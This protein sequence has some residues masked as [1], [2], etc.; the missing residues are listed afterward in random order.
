MAVRPGSASRCSASETSGYSLQSVVFGDSQIGWIAK[1]TGGVLRSEDGGR[2]WSS[3]LD[4]PTDYVSLGARLFWM[5]WIPRRCGR[6]GCQEL[7]CPLGHCTSRRRGVSI[8]GWRPELGEKIRDYH[9]Y[10]GGLDFIDPQHGWLAV[11]DEDAAI[12]VLVATT[13]GG[14]TWVGIE[15]I[16]PG[17][18]QGALGEVSFASPSHGWMIWQSDSGEAPGA[19]RTPR[20]VASPGPDNTP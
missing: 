14:E 6:D 2:T 19:S 13:D 11:T 5:Q 15:D 20:T 4:D 18:S 8:H 1:Q 7:N 3:A 10:L 12:P 9:S 17:Q 16:I